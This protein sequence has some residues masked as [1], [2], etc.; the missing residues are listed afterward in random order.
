MAAKPNRHI[1]DHLR[2][3]RKQRRV[4]E[5]ELAQELGVTQS[6]VSKVEHGRLTPDVGYVSRF[7]HLFRLE[8]SRTTE[9]FELLGVVPSGTTPAAFLRFVPFDLI[10]SDWSRRR[11]DAVRLAEQRTRRLWTYQPLVIPGLLQTAAYAASMAK[12]AGV[13]GS[14]A[15]ERTVKARLQRQNALRAPDKDCRF[16]ITESSL[17]SCVAPPKVLSEQVERLV[18]ISQNSQVPGQVRLGILPSNDTMTVTPTCG[19]YLFDNRVYLEL[20]HGDLWVLDEK[21]VQESYE[22]HFASL[23]RSALH[24]ARCDAILTRLVDELHQAR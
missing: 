18:K 3:I 14:R 17:R 5:K 21:H 15:I 20:L 7:A 13:R 10:S 6:T 8:V 9:L 11:Q 16:I 23:E 4:T 2:A 22:R 1:G 12:L 19:Y 24:G